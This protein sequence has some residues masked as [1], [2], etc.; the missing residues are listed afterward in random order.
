MSCITYTV[1]V[2]VINFITLDLMHR[3][4]EPNEFTK[5]LKKIYA[6]LAKLKNC[7]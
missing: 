4:I 7:E 1:L 5:I 2:D 3:S 6:G